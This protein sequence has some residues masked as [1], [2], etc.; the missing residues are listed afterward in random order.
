V[1]LSEFEDVIERDG[2]EVKPDGLLIKR[3][4]VSC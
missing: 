3:N 1:V 4:D 2:C